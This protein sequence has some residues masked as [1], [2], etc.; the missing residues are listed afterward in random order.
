MLD[1][2]GKAH[3]YC[4]FSVCKPSKSCA[5]ENGGH[6]STIYYLVYYRISYATQCS[7]CVRQGTGTLQHRLL[8]VHDNEGEGKE[9]GGWGVGVLLLGAMKC[10]VISAAGNELLIGSAVSS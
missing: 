3:V 8:Y 2:T 4:N 1:L 10:D 7:G 5:A 6:L 9:R